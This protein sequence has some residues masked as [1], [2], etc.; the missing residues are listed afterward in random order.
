MKLK[1]TAMLVLASCMTIPVFGQ[2]TP[3]GYGQGVN[4]KVNCSRKAEGALPSINA[5]L[6]LLAPAI[7]NT[8]TVSGTCNE[9]ILIQGFD[10]LTLVS[11]TGAT[12]N[13]A[14][15]GQSP[16]VDIEDSRRVEQNVG[17]EY[18]TDIEQDR[19]GRGPRFLH[20]CR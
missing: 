12:I 2:S 15:G 3:S 5:A 6:K 9:N 13:D 14:S 18:R 10:R 20:G 8:V 4:V 1:L 17:Q 16:V 7:S 11:T 19:E